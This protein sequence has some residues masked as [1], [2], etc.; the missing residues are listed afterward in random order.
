MSPKKM[1]S[2]FLPDYG[3]VST[4]DKIFLVSVKKYGHMETNTALRYALLQ[5]G[6]PDSASMIGWRNTK[7][8]G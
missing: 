1:F 7:R 6:M 3:F 4:S 2:S 5:D 8:S